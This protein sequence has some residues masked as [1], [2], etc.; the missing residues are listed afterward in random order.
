MLKRLFFTLCMV[1][2]APVLGQQDTTLLRYDNRELEVQ[3][4]TEEDLGPY[5]NNP[6]FDYEVVEPDITWW[7]NFTTWLGNLFR[8]F[9]E[10]LFGAEKAI[11]FFADFLRILP[12]I[13][14]GILLF[15][16]IKFFL[17]VNSN[18]LLY[19]KSNEAVVSLS[20]EEHI[21]KN[22]DIDQLIQKALNE[23]NYRLAI[24]YQY[25]LI[26]KQMSGKELITWEIQKTNDDYINE[27][28]KEELKTPFR[29][30][31]W[32]YDYVWYGD[33]PID[34]AKYSKAENKFTSLRKT[35]ENYA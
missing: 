14:I 30:I 13:L 33:F 32:L 26:L 34:E 9:F 3:T 29:V 24:R 15:L 11:G 19:S 12:Y 4:I 35:L 5:R 1:L 16:L 6:D 18:A 21:I 10:W 27:L 22:E 17:N 20:E 8:R 7:D 31:T 2:A 23:R 25:L 28:K